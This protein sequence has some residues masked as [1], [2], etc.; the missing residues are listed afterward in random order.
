[1]RPLRIAH[2][3]DLHLST[4]YRRDNLHSVRQTL[5]H[6]LQSGVDHVVI[7]GDITANAERRDYHLA[8]LLFS[9]FGLLDSARLTVT[10]GNHDIFGGVHTA[11]DLLEFPKRC[12]RTDYGG[13]LRTFWQHFAE[14]FEGVTYGG[15]SSPF[16][17]AK[18]VGNVVLIAVN[19]VARHGAA[20][21]PFGSNGEVQPGEARRLERLL[22]SRRFAGMRKILLVHH[23]F[24]RPFVPLSA[25]LPTLWGLLERQTM[26]LRGKRQILR[27]MTKYG[28]DMVLHGHHHKTEE[29]WKHG[30]HFGN[31]GATVLGPDPSMATYNLLT[32][33]DAG[34]TLQR[35]SLPVDR[36]EVSELPPVRVPLVP[37]GVHQAA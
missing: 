35:V 20:R 21:N 7:T 32:V 12:R 34:I 31:A 24:H 14:T 16:P 33:D 26:K 6:V 22:S 2:L 11:E 8:R 3:A 9:S 23:H 13:S 15:T 37:S 4:E 36:P 30:I 25:G 28:V 19:S 1:M 27:L 10:I 5:G 18:V 17:F 29:Y